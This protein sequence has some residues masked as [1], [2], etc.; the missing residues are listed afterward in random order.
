MR[1]EDLSAEL[2]PGDRLI[3]SRLTNRF[4]VSRP[5]IR[6]ALRQLEAEGLVSSIPRRGR[7]V[8]QLGVDEARDLYEVRASL[9]GLASGLFASRASAKQRRLLRE[10]MR[11]LTQAFASG[12]IDEL[13]A[14]KGRV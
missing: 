6:E 3:E 8:T 4:N 7:I 14:A 10:A 13:M 2:K 9:E 5:V 12:D 11:V 1:S